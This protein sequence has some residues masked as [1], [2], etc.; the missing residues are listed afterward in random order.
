V[1]TSSVT[2]RTGRLIRV[3]TDGL[4]ALGKTP[5]PVAVDDNRRDF[6]IE[7]FRT[8]RI[9]MAC[10]RSAA[11]GPSPGHGRGLAPQD[12]QHEAN[13]ELGVIAPVELIARRS[14]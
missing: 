6:A 8:L 4:A 10:R 12:R 7:F 3:I 9:R 11:A 5:P 13:I 1:T 14:S 2:T